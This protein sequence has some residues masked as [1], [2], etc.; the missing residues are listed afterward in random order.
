MLG[1]LTPLT[2][3][4]SWLGVLYYNAACISARNG[5]LDKAFSQLETAL[6][7]RTDLIQW[8]KEDPDLVSLRS[9]KRMGKM[10]AALEG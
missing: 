7:H 3:T 9:D 6:G 5:V 2:D 1:R 8:S 10:Y 4:P